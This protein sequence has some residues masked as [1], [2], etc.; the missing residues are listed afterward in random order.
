MTYPNGRP[1]RLS[2]SIDAEA[3]KKTVPEKVTVG[4]LTEFCK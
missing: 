2:I 3:D 1:P 4:S